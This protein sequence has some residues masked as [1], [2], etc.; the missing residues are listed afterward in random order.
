MSSVFA[1]ASTAAATSGSALR[2]I[3][4]DEIAIRIS[5]FSCAPSSPAIAC[6]RIAQ[7][8]ALRASGPI[9]SSEGESGIAPRS[10]T[11]P[12]VVLRPVM[13]QAAAGRRTE[14]PV[15]EPSAPNTSRAAT[16]APEPL[17]EP[18]VM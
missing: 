6:S 13:P 3:H 11:R 12:Q 4:A 15:S 10:G 5:P 17:E 16:A 14:P 8:S 7:S 2:S 9:V 1:A 18:P